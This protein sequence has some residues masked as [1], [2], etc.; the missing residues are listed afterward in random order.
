M[1]HWWLLP[2]LAILVIAVAAFYLT[3]RLTGGSGVRTDG[4]T[5]V[6]KPDEDE[7][8]PSI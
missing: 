4:R 2:G 3:V 7:N 6:D 8:S 1:L 5:M